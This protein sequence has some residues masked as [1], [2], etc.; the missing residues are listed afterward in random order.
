MHTLSD[1]KLDILLSNIIFTMLELTI[2]SPATYT[3]Q[4]LPGD[5]RSGRGS[6][7]SPRVPRRMET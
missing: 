5:S 7:S 2:F 3:A 1:D 6:V 4:D